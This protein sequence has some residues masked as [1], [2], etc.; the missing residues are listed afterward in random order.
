MNTTRFTLLCFHSIFLGESPPPA[1]R[2]C[3][4]RVG[5]IEKVVG[6]AKKL[7]PIALIGP[8]GIGKT[9]IALSVL[10][11]D[12]IKEKFG[13][14]RRFIRC[15]QFPASRT[16]FLAR[17][18]NII[19]AGVENPEDLTPLRRFLTSKEMFI[20]LDNAESILDPQGTNN[21]EIYATVDELCQF[22]TICICIT[23]RITTIPQ[24]CKF[25]EI[26]TLSMEAARDIFYGIYGDGTRSSIVDDLLQR[27]DLHPLSITLLATTASHNRWD[28]DRLAEEWGAHRAQV[29]QT[30]YN[31][32]LA[33]TIDLS[34]AS[35]TFRKLGPDARD[36]LGVVAFFPQGIDEKNLT[37]LFPTI[38]DRKTI[39][40]KFCLLSLTRRSNGFVTML[41]PIRDY[42]GPQDPTSSPILCATKDR[43]FARLLVGV[44]P[45]QPGFGEARWIMSE[46]VN[47]EHLLD[48]FASANADS[49]GVWGACIH[50]MEHLYWH[51]PRKTSLMPKME[52]LPD[53]HPS[54]PRCL[55]YL[56]QL[57]KR[58]GNHA[59]RIP[60]LTHALLLERGRGDESQVARTLRR[61][62]DA[63]RLLGRHGE[64]IQ[65]AKEALE[66][67]ERLGDTRGQASS[68][69][70]LAWLLLHSKQL[71]SAEDAASRTINLVSDKG[72]EAL[73]C[74][75]HRVLGMIYHSK[76][77]KEKA[78]HHFETALRIASPF[79]WRDEPFWNHH[80]LAHLFCNEGK[81]DDANTHVE[82]A[83]S[84][85]VDD[86]YLLGRAMEMQ[87]KIWH[88]QCKLEGAKLE[89][90]SALRIFGDLGALNGVEDCMDL[91]R[92]IEAVSNGELLGTL[93]HPA[94]INS[95][96]SAHSTPS[97]DLAGASQTPYN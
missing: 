17:L 89:V 33:T 15:D 73:V 80:S 60:L 81:F 31:G 2:A 54:K 25:S 67:N 22:K 97:G 70:C 63:N 48:I 62:S 90:L 46:D 38:P 21:R 24:Y 74:Q 44:Y 11:D 57:F 79:N 55:F 23:S 30:D 47:V 9:S 7:E 66:I 52:G 4:G 65:P 87:A 28:Y 10:H 6:L 56:S 39:F 37:W 35:P 68:L 45:D 13:N 91:L 51:K 95:P 41:A 53:D 50:F 20:V 43:Y 82:R 69:I 29:L 61:L 12:R 5:L 49:G 58:V 94:P 32:S 59:G 14:N 83:K 42:L 92:E 84:R 75:S 8:G 93:L 26:P 96:Y 34:L 3:F 27:L 72:Q 85:A 18:S 19:G 16:H 77:E 76:G 78:V 88:R 64:G 1:P 71:D 36:L 40:D 86:A